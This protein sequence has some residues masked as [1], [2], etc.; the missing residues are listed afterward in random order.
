MNHTGHFVDE[1]I[2]KSTT[3]PKYPILKNGPKNDFCNGYATG[4][5]S[6]VQKY[7]KSYLKK[8]GFGRSFRMKYTD[9]ID[10]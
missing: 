6:N 9:K 1:E 8:I 5:I 4:D 7:P 3:T 10:F 2:V